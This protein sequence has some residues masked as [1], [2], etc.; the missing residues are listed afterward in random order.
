MPKVTPAAASNTGNSNGSMRPQQVASGRRSLSDVPILGP[1]IDLFSS[2][3]LGITLLVILFI[4]SSIGS[5]GV[6]Y[7]IHPNIFDAGAWVHAQIRQFRP[8]EMTEFEWFHWWPFNLL[9]LLICLNI[10]ITTLRRIRFS[11]INLGVWMIHTGIIVLA[12][13]SVMYFWLKV[14]GDAPV[15][16]RQVV[17]RV[18][19]SFGAEQ[20]AFTASPGTQASLTTDMGEWRFEVVSID[21]AWEI[22][23]GDDAGTRAYSVNVLVEGPQGRFMRQLLSGYPRY[24]EDVLFTGDA[25]QPM[26]RAVKA[27]GTALVDESLSLSLEYQPQRWFYL[28]NDAA[29]SWA[30]Y[31]RRPGDTDW[32]ERPIHGL[33][34][35]N[36]YIASRDDVLQV[37]DDPLLPLDPIDVAIPP[38]DADDPFPD[39][40]F[41]ATGYLRYAMT[42]ST[43][44]AQ[45][46]VLPGTPLAPGVQFQLALGP[47]RSREYM[48]LAADPRSSR[49][50]EGLIR[51][52]VA[53]TQA[54]F[55]ALKQ[56]ATLDIEVPAAGIE[57][58]TPITALSIVDPSTPFT[59]VGDSGYSW[60]VRSV[61][62]ELPLGSGTAAVAIVELRTP[63]GEFRRWVFDDPRLTRDVTDQTAQDAHGAAR[64]M[65]E[66]I[67]IRYRPGSGRAAITLV[68]GPEPADL[69]VI[70]SPPAEP[71][72]VHALRVGAVTEL[73]GG[74][75]IRP[76]VYEPWARIAAKPLVVPREQR[77]RDAGEFFSQV[78][79]EVAG[80]RASF[81][82]GL[83]WIP[84]HRY[85][86]ANEQE[87]LRRFPY[88]P[89]TITLADG[90]QI[91]VL[92]SRRRHPL[93]AP[94]VLDDFV[95][96]TH[97]GGFTGETSTIRNYTSMVRF[98][99]MAG[100]A[101]QGSWGPPTAV[102][103]NDPIERDG[104][105]FFQAQWD[106][107]DEARAAGQRASA[108]LNYTVLGVGNREGV[109]VQ[110]AGCCIAVIGMIYAFYVKPILK[111]RRIEA[112]ERKLAEAQVSV[113]RAGA[114]SGGRLR[115]SPQPVAVASSENSS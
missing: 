79:L 15:A 2:V 49:S 62:D 110:L 112:A 69:H 43:L 18:P 29:K 5:A 111:R 34:L 24:T 40:Q 115:E 14:E 82:R 55:E 37:P 19:T 98:E 32:F 9:I 48:M 77:M 66:S 58:S 11:A 93:P 42:R 99:D 41:R 70:V 4:Y 47:G 27:R 35:Y 65:D 6:I 94:V 85:P 8:F 76:L 90:R 74:L 54:E 67:V 3:R 109:W 45:P 75:A 91:E 89:T 50:E 73:G 33:P 39:L 20:V 71:A 46:D 59:P 63:K 102:S 103:V 114:S 61:E 113:G 30:L 101:G 26:E 23:S 53:R 16:R 97:I 108:G 57:L 104:W 13:G 106:P 22:R 80:Q 64:L 88:Q 1:L 44:A 105:W 17:A 25:A 12:I 96:T 60:R 78:K 107:P 10:T 31:V 83:S 92:F 28:K 95:L 7:P 68:A 86:F 100:G 51:F 84:F 38:F 21:P 81:P 87:T 56:P 36:D 52:A 72:Q